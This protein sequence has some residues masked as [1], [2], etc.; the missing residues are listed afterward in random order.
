MFN[1]ISLHVIL[2]SHSTVVICRFDMSLYQLW[3]RRSRG[4]IMSY[5]KNKT[6]KCNRIEGAL[7]TAIHRNAIHYNVIMYYNLIKWNGIE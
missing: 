1:G 5:H 7:G 2:P 3:P 6:N 4:D